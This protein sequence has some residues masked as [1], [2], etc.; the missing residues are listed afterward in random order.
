LSSLHGLVAQ[1]MTLK[2]FIIGSNLSPAQT[3][4]TQL[5]PEQIWY[6]NAQCMATIMHINA[7][8]FL[9]FW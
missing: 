4:G 5:S 8:Y 1:A 3:S 6:S 9:T 2:V 7:Q